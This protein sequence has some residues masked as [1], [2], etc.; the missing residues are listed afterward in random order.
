MYIYQVNHSHLVE[1]IVSIQTDT[2]ENSPESVDF[3]SKKPIQILGVR[4][5]MKSF[6]E[7]LF[8]RIQKPTCSN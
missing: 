5:S 1:T 2:S 6:I 3:Y 8:D 4:R 7:Q